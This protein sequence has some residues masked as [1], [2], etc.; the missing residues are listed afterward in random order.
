MQVWFS[1]ICSCLAGPPLVLNL[2]LLAEV[3][4]GVFVSLCLDAC[5]WARVG[6]WVSD[7]VVIVAFSYH[8]NI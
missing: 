7:V 8:Y 1:Q 4:L 2:L 6:D 3:G 5:V